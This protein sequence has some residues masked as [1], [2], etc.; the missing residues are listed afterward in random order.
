MT[1]LRSLTEAELKTAAADLGQ[2]AYRGAQLFEWLHKKKIR[3]LDEALN[4]PHAFKDALRQHYSLSTL[5]LH[6]LQLSKDGTR[7]YLFLLPDGQA[8]ESVFMPYDYGHTVC[9]SSQVGCRMG[10]R[11][12]AS[13]LNGLSRNLLPGEMLEQVYRIE[14]ETGE[15]VDHLVVMGMGEPLDNLENLIRFIRLISDPKGKNLSQRNITVSTC[16]LVP[17]IARLAEEKLGITLALSLHA[18]ND[19]LRRTMMP[20]A[21]R[22]TIAETLAACDAYFKKTGRRMSYEY[23]LV[24]GSNDSEEMALAL[25][26][27]L[28][29]RNCHVNLIPVNPV[30]ERGFEASFDAAVLRFQK[31]LEKNGI[32]AT[33]RKKMGADIDGA[34]GQLRRRLLQ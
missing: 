24:R 3:D 15:R 16:G 25:A 22:Y 6:T 17:Q 11:F 1:D 8:V 14:E 29:G 2:P 9:V 10:C 32:N 34:C 19:E 33:I 31:T 21:N 27:L 5:Q 7:K 20:I 4:L 18:P 30:T 13:T 23:S 12:C 28:K 26:K